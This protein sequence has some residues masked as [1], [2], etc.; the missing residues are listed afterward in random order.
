MLDFLYFCCSW[1]IICSRPVLQGDS[2][3]EK[4]LSLVDS[5]N[6]VFVIICGSFHSMVGR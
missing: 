4:M 1:L 6:I 5:E 3:L 2:I